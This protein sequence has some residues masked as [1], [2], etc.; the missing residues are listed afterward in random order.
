MKILRRF[1]SWEWMLIGVLI[2]EMLFFRSV[3]RVFSNLENLL[4][5]SN[6]FAH[7]MLA[8]LPLTLVIITGGIDISIASVMGLTSIVLGVTWQAGLDIFVAMVVALLVGVLCG[9][10]N[11]L[12]VTN[13]DI[14]PLII[15]L[16]TNFLFAGIATGVSRTFVASSYEGISGIP[17]KFT[18][19][20]HEAI[21]LIPYPMILIII[22]VVIY[23]IFLH[24]TRFGRTLYLI[25]TNPRTAYYSGLNVRAITTTAYVLTSLGAAMG[26]V[27]LSSYFT[28]ARADLGSEAL[29]PSITAVVLGGTSILGGSGTV[30]GTFIAVIILGYLKQ[31]LLSVGITN[32]VSQV[33][34]GGLLILVLAVKNIFIFVNQIQSTRR[35][36]RATEFS[37]RR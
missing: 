29:L 15:T 21:G 3:S 8:A 5:S 23:S 25:G 18:R 26:G 2:V 19:L 32:D 22:L 24:K 4:Y 7:I 16:G 36:L 35:A 20:S 37:E 14:N 27:M 10:L 30:F 34:I 13:T 11:G 6:D 31:G 17:S 12:L 28:S 33:V 1:I 9:L